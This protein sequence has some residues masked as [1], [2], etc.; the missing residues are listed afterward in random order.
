M[1]ASNFD[2]SLEH[3]LLFEGGYVNDP[4]DPGGETN[5]GISKRSYPRE[6]I[7]GMTRER[8]AAIY[9]RDYWNRVKGDQLPD[10]IDLVAFDP[11]VNS[12]VQR[13]SRWLQSALG[14]TQDGKIGPQTVLAAQTATDGVAVIKRACAA[15]MGFLRGLTS[16][17]STYSRGWTRRVASVEATAVAMYTRSS[18]AVRQERKKASTTAKAQATGAAGSAASGAGGA[19]LDGLPD[20]ATYGLIALAVVVAVVLIGKSRTNKARATAYK[21]Q[22]KAA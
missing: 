12:G 4:R 1:T 7:R 10:G 9:R 6:D 20:L 5:M 14:V 18:V 22:E 2:A 15:R 17:W 8:A 13:G 16:L 11:A 21:Q 19:S 3:V